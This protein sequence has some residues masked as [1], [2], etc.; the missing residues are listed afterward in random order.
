MGNFKFPMSED[1]GIVDS[2]KMAN[3][4]WSPLN[5]EVIRTHANYFLLSFETTNMMSSICISK[6]LTIIE[7]KKNMTVQTY[8]ICF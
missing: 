7:K 2:E 5:I 6:N 8:K 1:F 4:L 3:A